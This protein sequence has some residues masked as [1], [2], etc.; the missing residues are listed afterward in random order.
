ML[1]VQSV[2]MYANSIDTM[3]KLKD[4]LCAMLV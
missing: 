1:C 4:V 3:C 2:A